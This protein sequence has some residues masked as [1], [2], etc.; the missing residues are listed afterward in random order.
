MKFDVAVELGSGGRVRR[1]SSGSVFMS[2]T[3]ALFVP[4]EPAAAVP[5]SVSV[6]LFPARSLIVPASEVRRDV[7][8]V[9]A[10]VAGRDRVVE[11]Q[12][13][14]ARSRFRSSQRSTPGSRT[15][16]RQTSAFPVTATD[17][18]NVTVIGITTPGLVRAVR[19]RRGHVR[20]GRRYLVD[21][22]GVRSRESLSCHR[23]LAAPGTCDCPARDPS[24]PS[25]SLS[26]KPRTGFRPTCTDSIR[27]TV[28]P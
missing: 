24:R 25:S 20:H 22:P 11:G 9:R 2:T 17:S 1:L 15:H 21:H 3:I 19:G 6:A 5:G 8:Q 28:A 27:R 16:Q 13:A 18:L 14:R 23:R 7:V 26:Y 10:G 4:S 12:R